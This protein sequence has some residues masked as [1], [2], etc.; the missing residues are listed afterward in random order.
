MAIVH[1]KVLVYQEGTLASN[2][3]RHL[4]RQNFS[5]LAAQM[6]QGTTGFDASVSLT[7]DAGQPVEVGVHK[8]HSSLSLDHRG[9]GYPKLDN[10]IR[11][12][13]SCRNERHFHVQESLSVI[14]LVGSVLY[15][16]VVYLP[17]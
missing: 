15:W 5:F 6:I 3:D 17:L 4:P 14:D 10:S 7:N 16:L 11:H 2:G 12:V 13:G 9:K 1:S 8:Q